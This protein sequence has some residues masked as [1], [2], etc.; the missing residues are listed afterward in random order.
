MTVESDLQA[1][2][3]RRAAELVKIS[4]ATAEERYQIEA[5]RLA[6]EAQRQRQVEAAR[7]ASIQVEQ[8]AAERERRAKLEAERAAFESA[9][10]IELERQCQEVAWIASPEGQLWSRMS[11]Q[12]EALVKTS[13]SSADSLRQIRNAIAFL[14]VLCAVCFVLSRF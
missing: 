10:Q 9:R 11:I 6:D 4:R 13:A 1:E 3:D 7:Q 2:A 14:I 5:K 12:L 8:V